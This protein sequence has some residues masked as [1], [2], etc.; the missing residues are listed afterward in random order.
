MSLRA[1]TSTVMA[2][3]MPATQDHHV[4]WVILDGRDKPGHDDCVCDH[5][6]EILF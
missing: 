2:G 1:I 5:P 3:F 4:A 6:K